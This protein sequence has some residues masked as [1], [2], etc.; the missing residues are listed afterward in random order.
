L[1]KPGPRNLGVTST[2]PRQPGLAT[3]PSGGVAGGAG[4][5]LCVRPRPNPRGPRRCRRV[6]VQRLRVHPVHLSVR[7][8]KPGARGFR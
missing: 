3:D 1:G 2:W 6:P 7:S 4:R 5:S 8:T